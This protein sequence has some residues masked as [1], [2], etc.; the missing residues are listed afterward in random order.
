MA[1]KRKPPKFGGVPQS[2]W[3]SIGFFNVGQIGK[4][5]ENFDFA[6]WEHVYNKASSNI[7]VND[8]DDDAGDKED[9]DAEEEQVV[10]EDAEEEEKQVVEEKRKK[11]KKTKSR[12][13]TVV[14]KVKHVLKRDELITV[15]RPSDS[16]K[17]AI[18]NPESLLFGYFVRSR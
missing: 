15:E 9:K 4:P 18:T 5:P 8:D 12:D 2:S 16:Q 7:V 14:C 6:W 3:F 11:V 1:M 13:K 17:P 10:E